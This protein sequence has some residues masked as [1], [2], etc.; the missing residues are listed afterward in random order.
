MKIISNDQIKTLVKTP[1]IER[2]LHA[3]LLT[4]IKT[5][6]EVTIL[7]GP[8]Q[9]G[10]S[11]EIYRCIE[12]LLK[13]NTQDVFMYNLDIIP[14]EFE[15][16]DIFLATILAQKSGHFATK[17]YVFLDEAQRLENVGLFIKYLYDQNKNIKFILTGSASLDIKAKIKEPLTG[18]KQEFFLAPL[19]L[20]EIVHFQGINI[21]N[22]SSNFPLLENILNDY[23]LFGGYPEVVTLTTKVL[24]TAKITEIAESYT[25]R[26]ISAFFNLT[27]TKTIQLV[28]RFLAES[29]GNI[30]SK[31]NISKI[32]GI[33]KY[34]TEKAL[35]ALE[36]SFIVYLIPPMAK[37]PSKELIHRPKIFFQDLGIRNAILK[38][39]DPSLI[40]V[41][42][43]QLFENA[44][45]C[46]L[47]SIFGKDN[48]K[49]WRTTNQTEVDFIVTKPNGKAA[50]IE[51]KYQWE[52][53][54]SLPK[55]LQSI[56]Q[57]YPDLIEEIKVISKSDYWKLF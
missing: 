39:L 43:G 11:Q 22:L 37:T 53:K 14:E 10:K 50:A 40:L 45:A 52:S 6:P 13:D 8:R 5:A 26:D 17:T 21:N 19:T 3:P 44:I 35:E 51:T 56:K 16:P 18:R 24:K 49:F 41:D 2:S 23:L 29:I 34:Q 57:Q 27:S 38:K 46:E 4:H 33:P 25:L 9:V 28:A 42:K 48:L 54:N 15:N 20:K 1:F 30:L 32:G 31:E 55:N 12:N 47:L 36:K 7:Y